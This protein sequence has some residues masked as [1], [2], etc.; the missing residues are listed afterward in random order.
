MA[1]HKEPLVDVSAGTPADPLRP[2]TSRALRGHAALD[3]WDRPLAF[4]T[5][6]T[7]GCVSHAS[8]AAG[9]A[10]YL[11]SRQTELDVR[12]VERRGGGGRWGGWG[13][14]SSTVIVGQRYGSTGSKRFSLWVHT[15]KREVCCCCWGRWKTAGEMKPAHVLISTTRFFFRCAI[16]LNWMARQ[17]PSAA[18]SLSVGGK[19]QKKSALSFQYS[20]F[21]RC[22]EIRLLPDC[23][24][25][26]SWFRLSS[27]LWSS[28]CFLELPSTWE[29]EKKPTWTWYLQTF[30][31]TP[32]K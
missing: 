31:K 4:K 26:S 16:S 24:R 9:P 20:P 21:L 8:L 13:W 28:W 23:W 12:V 5:L 11:F 14:V 17:L 18:A 3:E 1:P 25:W 30:K 27:P 15:G 7:W 2:F 10:S 22:V 29:R 32:T 6:I 19:P